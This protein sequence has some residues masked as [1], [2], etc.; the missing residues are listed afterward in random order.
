MYSAMCYSINK[1]STISGMI[2]MAYLFSQQ[3]TK[4]PNYYTIEV[5]VIHEICYGSDRFYLK[6]FQ[7]FQIIYIY[8][9]INYYDQARLLP[10]STLAYLNLL[11]WFNRVYFQAIASHRSMNFQNTCTMRWAVCH[12]RSTYLWIH[13]KT[14]IIR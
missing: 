5:V 2:L 9:L 10:T 6:T 8:Q 3:I 4:M 7:C 12:S 13:N 14:L 11:I 1:T